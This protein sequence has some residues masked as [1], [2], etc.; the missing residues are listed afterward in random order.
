VE[1]GFWAIAVV[2]QSPGLPSLRIAVTDANTILLAW[3]AAS[4]G[5]A[6][7]QNSDLGALNWSNVTN[8]PTVMGDE[9]QVILPL[10]PG[11]RFFRLK[12]P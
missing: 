9:N 10:S 3:S 11:N 12:Y 8:A 7:Q 4:A 1:G 5:F 2:V 6:L